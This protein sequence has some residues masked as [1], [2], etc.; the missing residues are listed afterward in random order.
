M[1]FRVGGQYSLDISAPTGDIYRLQGIY[2]EIDEPYRLVFTWDTSDPPSPE[3]ATLVTVVFTEQDGQTHVSLTHERFR[4]VPAR[5]LHSQG[6]D[7]C[8]A[9]LQD[10]LSTS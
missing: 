6:W 9:R 4:D 7:M 2:Q 8:F 10:L 3:N 5:V 1:D